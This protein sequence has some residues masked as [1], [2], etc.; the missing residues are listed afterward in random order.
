M[1]ELSIIIPWC[2]EWPQVAFTIRNIA[3]E[4]RDRVDFE[5]I[6][7]DNWSE[8]TPGSVRPKDRSH[9]ML[10]GTAKMHPWLKVLRYDEKLSHWNA[11]NLGV[12]NSTGKFLWFCDAHC[13]VG[14]DSLYDMFLLYRWSHRALMARY[15]CP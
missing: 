11:K 14:R 12:Q 7:I 9:P 2:N 5:I 3:E 8:N 1:A 10:W 4:L 6:A 15:I 13:I